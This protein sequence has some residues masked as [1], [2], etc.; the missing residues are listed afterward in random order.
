MK[1]NTLIK[2]SIVFTV[3][4]SFLMFNS[5]K[6][7]AA[8]PQKVEIDVPSDFNLSYGKDT[9]LELTALK[10]SNEQ[11]EVKLSFDEIANININRTVKL[12]DRL[13]EAI[14]VTADKKGILIRS[15]LL[16]P[17]S[18][19]STINGEK[20]P[21][22][23]KV[24]IAAVNTKGV[25]VGEKSTTF[26][27]SKSEVKI[28]GSAKDKSIS[29]VYALFSDKETLFDLET[30]LIGLTGTSWSFQSNTV[31][32]EK[33]SIQNNQLKFAASTG[34]L[35]QLE[36]KTYE[37][38]PELIKDGFPVASAK[39]RIIFI[40][41]IKFLFGTYYP[42]MDITIRYPKL[43]VDLSSGYVSSAPVFYP[44]KYRG[45]FTIERIELDGQLYDNKE[46][47]FSINES[48]GVITAKTNA[49]LKTG[50]Y[51]FNIKAT[52]TNGLEFL[53]TITLEYE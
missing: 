2:P 9:T 22:T 13:K 18:E 15:S 44:E 11:L 42:D 48:T 23:Y 4:I 52:A 32:K 14:Q 6:K 39:V 40:P 26:K 8:V 12:H 30:S 35:S 36:E 20:I 28:K 5:C 43:F 31:D 16:Y 51:A 25:V 29:F 34:K 47:N 49:N 50:S 33:I 38:E 7:D 41:A 3:I 21:P 1:T 37:V 10:S 24:K 17:N 27:L 45:K 53:T 46:G 19:T